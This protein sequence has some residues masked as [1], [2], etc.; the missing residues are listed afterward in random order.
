M[1]DL[2]GTGKPARRMQA[3]RAV[4]K[5]LPMFSVNTN[6]G[7]MAALLKLPDGK[8]DAILAEASQG[9]VVSAAHR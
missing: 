3:N 9:E 6:L 5:E 1:V 2:C 4:K 8:L 7:A